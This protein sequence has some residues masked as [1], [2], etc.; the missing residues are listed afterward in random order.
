[1][2]TDRDLRKNKPEKVHEEAI[3]YRKMLTGMVRD[4]RRNTRSRSK[5]REENISMLKN[6]AVVKAKKRKVS[7]KR[8]NRF[9]VNISVDS[10]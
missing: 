3:E 10:E 8:N 9:K 6:K 5:G 1:M 7:K 4:F 2:R